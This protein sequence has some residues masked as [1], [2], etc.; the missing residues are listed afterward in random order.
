MLY[1]SPVSYAGHDEMT[2]PGGHAARLD[3]LPDGLPGLHLALNGLLLHAWK[4]RA[5]YGHVLNPPP[6]KV[7]IRRTGRLLDEVLR[8]DGAPLHVARPVERRV[9]VDCRH[10]AVLLC[11]VLRHR[12]VPARPRCG[13]ASYL[14]DGERLEDHWA[15]E[16]WSA[17]TGRWVM[18]DADLQRH[19]VPADAFLTG[20]R[21][22]RLATDDGSL[23][24]RC[25]FSPQL[26]GWPALRL[27]LVR[28][29]AAVNGFPSVSGDGW[30]LGLAPEEA[31]TPADRRALDRA[32]ELC[33]LD[34]ALAEQRA[35]YATAPGLAPPDTILHFES[36]PDDARPVRWRQEP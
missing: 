1:S 22:W 34:D 11:A 32:A 3:E 27:N 19:D 13:F 35:L 8:L 15:C 33:G 17:A 6:R 24:A 25:A 4:A 10:F 9:V 26:R 21:A 7:T 30:G 23:A 20:A 14:E 12:G 29:V 16:Y 5:W 28:D 2:D 36:S 31:L 18:E